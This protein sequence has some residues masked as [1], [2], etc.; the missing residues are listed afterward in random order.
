MIYV[1][2]HKDY[3]CP[4]PEGYKV[5]E[6]GP[7]FKDQGDNIN[8]LNPYIN[9]LT[10][11]YWIWKNTSD[12]FVGL[13]HYRRYFTDNGILTYE[14]AKEK[15]IGHDI[16]ITTPVTFEQSLYDILKIDSGGQEAF[17]LYRNLIF[18]EF[19]GFAKYLQ[20]TNRVNPRNMFFCRKDL[21][22][23]YCEWMFPKVIPIAERY[24]EE[25]PRKY[26]NQDRLIGY[27]AERLM[28]YWIIKNNLDFIETDYENIVE[29]DKCFYQ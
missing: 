11:L 16:L 10:G 7:L 27:F 12:D 14:R 18:R 9:E 2:K 19:P 13:C 26:N 8:D 21:I 20:T 15:L 24:R 4:I 28:S 29:G 6:V 25:I 17:W 22:D 1:I 23:K 5:L 3:D